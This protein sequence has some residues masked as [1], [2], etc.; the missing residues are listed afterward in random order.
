MTKL[1]EKLIEL[2][3]KWNTLEK[4]WI[5]K[6]DLICWIYLYDKNWIPH[7]V[8]YTRDYSCQEQ[9]DNLQEAF[10]EMQRDLKILENIDKPNE[11]IN[12]NNDI[13]NKL[14][15]N[16]VKHMKDLGEWE[17]NQWNR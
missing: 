15:E 6:F 13:G 14:W 7:H 9:I 10:N 4:A 12:H 3:Y 16:D 2:G 1:E 5:K 8:H 17:R 11:Q